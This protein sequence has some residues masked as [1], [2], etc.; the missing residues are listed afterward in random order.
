MERMPEPES[1][2]LD[3]AL[4]TG[5]HAESAQ[6]EAVVRWYRPVL[7]VTDDKF[8]SQSAN[9]DS[10]PRFVDPNEAASKGLMNT[11]EGRRTV[12][13]PVIRSVGRI[14]LINNVRYPWVGT[15]WIIGSDPGSDI[16]DRV[17]PAPG[18]R[19]RGLTCR[20]LAPARAG[21]HSTAARA[22]R[23]RR[24]HHA[25]ADFPLAREEAR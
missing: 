20:N 24:G 23:S 22:R 21:S 13:D 4:P 3:P 17:L 8:V 11:L 16:I 14:E 9:K 15:G 1:V 25:A 2:P 12:L 18:R 5:P 19:A 10:D 6:Y 7:M